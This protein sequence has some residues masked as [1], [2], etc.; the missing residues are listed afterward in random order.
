MKF[1]NSTLYGNH[2]QKFCVLRGSSKVGEPY[3][4][5][6]QGITDETVRFPHGEK[7]KQIFSSLREKTVSYRS[8]KLKDNGHGSLSVPRWR[9]STQL[10][11]DIN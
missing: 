1:Q 5:S 2:K 6:D 3:Q 9:V 4:L 8:V 11:I 10:A 7:G